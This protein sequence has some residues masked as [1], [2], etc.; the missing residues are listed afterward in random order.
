M[1]KGIY[2]DNSTIARPSHKTVCAMMPF[3]DDLWGSTSAPHMAGQELF[4]YIEENYRALYSLIGAKDEDT[5]ILT[6]SGAEAVNHAIFAAYYDETRTT[7]KNQ[8]ITSHSD[9][10]PALLAIS[11]LENMGCVAKIVNPDRNGMVTAEIIAD[12]LSPRTA[13]VSLSWVNGLTGVINSIAEIAALCKERGVLLHIDATHALGKLFFDLEEIGADF[14]SCNGDQLHSPKGSGLLYIKH[15]RRF[16]PFIVG[17]MEQGGL[18][19]G[20]LNMPALL[21][22]GHAAQEAIDGR[23]L[24]CTEVARLRD[25]LEAG[26]LKGYPG[27]VVF[28]SD[29]P[30]I[31]SITAIAFPGIANE[32]MLFALN[33]K[34]LYASIGG[35]SQ[36]QIALSLMA[37]GVDLTLARTA[38]SFSLSRET[39]ED[40]IERAIAIIVDVATKL[41]KTSEKLWD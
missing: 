20:A 10:A 24:M 29:Q 2:L 11:R 23:D 19:A 12:A 41:Q 18:R 32:M 36:Q 39:T 1:V 9:E 14:I 4:P 33:R 22:F 3:F 40:E 16:T 7:G 15:G 30:R 34:H 37:A 13:L 28:F 38:L 5:V 35:G 21:G 31:S 17:G 6:S 25:Q 8:F 26:V 27:A